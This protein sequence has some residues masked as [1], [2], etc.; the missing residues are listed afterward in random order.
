MTAHEPDGTVILKAHGFR[1]GIIPSVGGILASLDWHGP[2]GKVHPLLFSPQ[3][4]GPTTGA[5]NFL[6]AWAMVP[7][8][9]RA[10]DCVIDDGMQR[11]N[12]P[13][14]DPARTGNIH[15]FGWQSPWSVTQLSPVRLVTAHQRSGADD[16]YAYH[17]TQAITL[18]DGEVRLD[19]GVTNRADRALPFGLGFH[20]WFACAPDTTLRMSSR[21]AL[22][23]GPGYRATGRIDFADGGPFGSGRIVRDV[24]GEL[25]LS[26]VDWV[27]D[28]VF[29]TPSQGLSISIG[30]SDSFR[31]PVLWSP[32]GADFVCFEP[33]SH[34]IGA[35][36]DAMARSITPLARLEPGQTLSGWMTLTPQ[37]ILAGTGAEI[38][39]VS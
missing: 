39:H 25:A 8:A 32:P 22:A 38:P 12:V 10:F 13:V 15:G 11:F 16:P 18:K 24:T 2:S 35:P 34:G 3:G 7:F 23:L 20:P 4:V 31:H 6:G 5:P 19:L 33:Q 9:N 26:Y 17:A 30:A 14:N 29:S 28:A 36:G 1:A 27:G 21:G 37:E